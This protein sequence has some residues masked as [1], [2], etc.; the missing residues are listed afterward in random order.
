MVVPTTKP[1]TALR[2]PTRKLRKD[3]W[4]FRA[5]FTKLRDAYGMASGL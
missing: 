5:G 1:R 2:E 3:T 4:L